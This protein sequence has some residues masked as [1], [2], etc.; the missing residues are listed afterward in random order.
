M[1]TA[2]N[3][4]LD[5]YGIHI[6]HNES[7]LVV[8][9]VSTFQLLETWKINKNHWV[10]FADNHQFSRHIHELCFEQLLHIFTKTLVE[11]LE[12]LDSVEFLD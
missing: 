5:F 1:S 8:L 6:W 9:L 3:F 12:F 2:E 7:H 11:I 10:P 4:A